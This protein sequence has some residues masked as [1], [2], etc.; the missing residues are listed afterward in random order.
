VPTKTEVALEEVITHH[1]SA[2]FEDSPVVDYYA[3]Q[4]AVA[5]RA[6]QAGV[7]LVEEGIGVAKSEPKRGIRLAPPDLS[8]LR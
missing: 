6:R 1:A 3:H 4:I 8:G 5:V 2:F 7:R